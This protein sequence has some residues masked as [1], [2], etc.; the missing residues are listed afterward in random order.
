MHCTLTHSLSH[1]CQWWQ[2]PFFRP[3]S[4]EAA[5]HKSLLSVPSHAYLIKCVCFCFNFWWYTPIF[6][7]LFLFQHLSPFRDLSNTPDEVYKDPAHVV[8]RNQVIFAVLETRRV[9]NGQMFE[10]GRNWLL[11]VLV[12][13]FWMSLTLEPSPNH[14]FNIV[15]SRIYFLCLMA[16]T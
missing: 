10:H 4:D 5:A 16:W 7:Y 14:P 12:S 8:N 3:S 9:Y 15:R 2:M 11:L 1:W 6:G 13:I